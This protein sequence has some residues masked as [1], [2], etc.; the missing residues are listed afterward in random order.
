MA[1]VLEDA[2]V[3]KEHIE[4]VSISSIIKYAQQV[5]PNEACGFV[6]DN[7]AV[8]PAR[9]IVDSLHNKSLTS[10]NAFLIDPESWKIASSRESPI[11]VI[12]H[13]HTN[14]DS[15]MS[16]A[17]TTFLRWDNYFY[18]VVALVDTNP[19]SAKLFWWQDKEMN[20]IELSI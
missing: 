16:S 7:G 17:D 15:N 1:F 14:G 9:N 20:E 11:I 8:H 2:I 6:L 10:R 12:Y 19:V 4:Q 18:V 3:V 5:F 13:S